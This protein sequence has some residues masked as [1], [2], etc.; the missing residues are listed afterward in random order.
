[1]ALDDYLVQ[2]D[3]LDCSGRVSHTLTL[4]VDGLVRIDFANGR[5]AIVDPRTRRNLTPDV[6]VGP[7]L[8]DRAAHL[9]PW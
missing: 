8:L 1:M 9:R 7:A 2:V 6:P 3:L 4:L 5:R